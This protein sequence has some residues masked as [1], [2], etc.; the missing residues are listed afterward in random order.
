MTEYK[1]MPILDVMRLPRQAFMDRML[2]W[3]KEFHN[4]KYITP[5]NPLECPVNQ[6]VVFN[7]KKCPR[8][9]VPNTTACP[10]CGQPCCPDCYIHTVEQLSR[11][12]GYLG[13]VSSW[14]AAKQ[15]EFL[16]RD[17]HKLIDSDNIGEKTM[18]ENDVL[19]VLSTLNIDGKNVTITGQLNRK[20]YLA[21]NK[22][23]EQI[24]GKWNRKAKAHVFDGDPTDRV[25]NV[26]ECGEL[27]PE[28][29]TG[30]F[31][32]PSEIVDKMIE[33]ADLEKQHFILEPSAGQGHIAD[34]ICA[35]LR[36]NPYDIYTCELLPENRAILEEKGYYVRGD[37]IEFAHKRGAEGNG[38]VFDRILMNPPF[39]RQADIEH[40]TIAFDLLAPSGILVAIM[41]AGVTFRENKKTVEFRENIFEP[42]C[43]H[44]EH[45]PSGA[46]KE[47]GTM[48]KTIMIRLE[49]R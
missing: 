14:N 7:H 37:F 33:L 32:T 38:W 26:I 43:T 42:H 22:V 10:L 16:D 39:E 34:R 13:N 47:S 25:N 45:L 30:Y 5:E 40:V 9:M 12:T 44:V 19:T 1:P 29:K 24:G 18:I 31:P 3:K 20:L 21:V 48:V 46:F 41:S 8:Q 36:I 11:V 23:L 35:K 49:R 28:V 15:Q 2:A 4:E 17:R 27:D 6:W